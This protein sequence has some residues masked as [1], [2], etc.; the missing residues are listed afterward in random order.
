[1]YLKPNSQMSFL[2]ERG[3]VA[4]TYSV[5]GRNFS[6]SCKGCGHFKLEATTLLKKF[7]AS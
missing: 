1:M 2:G 4:W 5:K 7:V 3:K 6:R